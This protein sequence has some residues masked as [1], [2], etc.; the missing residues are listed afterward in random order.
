[1]S[2]TTQPEIPRRFPLTPRQRRLRYMTVIVLGLI[3]LM[4]AFGVLHPF[5]RMT[6]PVALTDGSLHAGSPELRALRRAFAAK[7]LLIGLYWGSV[8]LLTL[9]L[10]VFAWLYT[11]EIHLQELMARRDIWHE[12]SGRSREPSAGPDSTDSPGQNRSA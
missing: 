3:A 1:M 6:P 7:L 10:P 5:F 12:V 4:I 2:D 11:R 8:V 9:L